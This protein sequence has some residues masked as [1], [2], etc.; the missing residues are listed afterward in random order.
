MCRLFETIKVLDG[1]LCN[2]G[3]HNKRFNHARSALFG[4]S[5]HARLQ[6]FIKIPPEY[7]EGIVKCRIVYTRD[8]ETIEYANYKKKN[9]RTLRIVNGDALD[10]SYKYCDRS[11]IDR[12]LGSRDG[13]DDIIIVRN[14]RVTD[15]SFC[16]LVFDDG[17]SLI[18]PDLP[19]LQGTKREKLLSEGIVV[20]QKI[21]VNDLKL[22][23]S[24]HLINAMLDLGECWLAIDRVYT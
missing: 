16:N 12:L 23:Q 10:Y 9:I 8:I 4:C 13:C 5:G 7:R 15:S 11:G 14:G 24:V 19:L 6:D 21:G 2:I 18:T 1:A 3:F 22:F 20:R 17:K